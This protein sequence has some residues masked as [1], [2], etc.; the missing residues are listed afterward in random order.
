[1]EPRKGMK[2]ITMRRFLSCI[3]V[4]CCLGAILGVIGGLMDWS[5]GVAFAVLVATGTI[6]V[7]VALRESLF[8]GFRR[9][10]DK[11]QHSRHA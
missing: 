1:M 2:V 7:T 9:P 11:R 3:G 5:S 10:S 6:T 8:E 4:A